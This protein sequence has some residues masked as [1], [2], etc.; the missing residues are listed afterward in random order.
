MLELKFFGTPLVI[1]TAIFTREKPMN[2]IL[3]LLSICIFTLTAGTAHSQEVYNFYFNKNNTPA[4]LNLQQAGGSAGQ[5]TTA[6]PVQVP[7]APDATVTNTPAAASATSTAIAPVAPV[8]DKKA[9]KYEFGVG[10]FNASGWGEES[11]SDYS[12]TYTATDHYSGGWGLIGALRINKFISVD[13]AIASLSLE[14][15]YDDESDQYLYLSAGMTITPL[16]INVFGHD[17]VELGLL[18]GLMTNKHYTFE[19]NYDDVSGYSYEMTDEILTI[20]PYLGLKIGFNITN[21]LV[22]AVEGRSSN[23]EDYTNSAGSMSLRYKI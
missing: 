6:Q 18:A 8:V 16:R 4:S 1:P 2:N 19:E 17:L 23:R 9:W 14:D 20:D 11:Y 3:R 22:L 15:Y 13:G 21:K 7:M 10:Y 12:D 5:A